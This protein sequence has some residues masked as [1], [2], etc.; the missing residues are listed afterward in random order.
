MNKHISLVIEECAANH[1]INAVYVLQDL[2]HETAPL[3]DRHECSLDL[4]FHAVKVAVRFDSD[5]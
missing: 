5:A 4:C 3:F 2:L 1:S